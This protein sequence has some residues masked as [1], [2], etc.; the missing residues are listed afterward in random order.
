MDDPRLEENLYHSKDRLVTV[1]NQWM[2]IFPLWS[3]IFLGD[4]SCYSKD[5][6]ETPKKEENK[7][8][9]TNTKKE[10]NK[11]RSTN[12]LVE[13]YFGIIKQDIPKKKRL[14]PAEFVR[15]QYMNIKGK[16]SEI[17]TVV[18]SSKKVS[19][20]ST[21]KDQEQWKPKKDSS[22]KNASTSHHP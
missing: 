15:K 17:E 20:K 14:R 10:E 16:L 13:N 5:N 18:P 6:E 1:L 12:S 4:L 9:S 7:T 2:S 19:K 21:K 3:G 8:R 22:K 11:T